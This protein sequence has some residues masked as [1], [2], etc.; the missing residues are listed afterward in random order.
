MDNKKGIVLIGHNFNSLLGLA[1][2][3]GKKEWNV[4]VI[5]MRYKKKKRISMTLGLY[6]ESH[7]KYI[8]Y[9]RQADAEDHKSLLRLLI[10]LAK[11]MPGKMILLPVDDLTAI[12]IDENFNRLNQY[13]YI[14]NAGNHQGMVIKLMN[15]SLQN[16]MACEVGLPTPRG[17]T[18]HV[19]N[20]NYEIP[21]GIVYPCFA[22][23][24]TPIIDRKLFMGRCETE[25]E[26]KKLLDSVAKISNCEMLLEEYVPIEKEYGCVGVVYGDQV[27]IPGIT[28][29]TQLG[30][31]TNAGVTVCGKI[32]DP[33]DYYETWE[34]MK[35]FIL[36]TGFQGLFDIDLY[37]SNGTIYFNEL[38]L[39][40]GAEGVGTLI[41]D[42]NISEIFAKSVDGK[43]TSEDYS[44]RANQI[45]FVNERPL[46]SD[47]G[48]GYISWAQCCEAIKSADYRLIYAEDDR[49]PYYDS[50]FYI[51]RQWLRRQKS[52]IRQHGRY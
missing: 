23:T 36:K 15:K 7:S 16:K 47:Y 32:H 25:S 4:S 11:A 8:S 50:I 34:K 51:I 19:D 10:S 37:E 49:G 22:K 29:K 17:W 13:Y 6:P 12:F 24:A 14:P 52:R 44:V 1:R 5:R 28:E 31:G 2:A 48:E 26:L 43:A 27:C 46:Y 30:H 21:T 33:E 45:T 3:M 20:K 40:M 35:K 41:A 38:N 42:A 9:Y 18:V 39:R